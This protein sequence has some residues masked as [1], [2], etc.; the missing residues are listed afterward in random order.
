M[1]Q[2]KYYALRDKIL[3]F[4]KADPNG[5]RALH[6]LEAHV[7]ET[8]RKFYLSVTL[9]RMKHNQGDIEDAE[10]LAGIAPCVRLKAKE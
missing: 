9:D 2:R 4:L 5:T 8:E 7:T 10:A 1:T 6:E 3:K